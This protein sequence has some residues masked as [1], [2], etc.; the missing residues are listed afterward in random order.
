MPW[1]L[2][3]ESES[4]REKQKVRGR[5]GSERGRPVLATMATRTR[6]SSRPC[7]HINMA[8]CRMGFLSVNKNSDLGSHLK[9]RN[10]KK[11]LKKTLEKK[12]RMK[13]KEQNLEEFEK[14]Y[15]SRI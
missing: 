3:R 9:S 11:A 13:I 10:T 2:C 6:A 14:N 12:I 7:S 5:R 1:P 15:N 8:S 4:E